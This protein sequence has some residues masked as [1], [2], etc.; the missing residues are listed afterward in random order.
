MALYD[1][2]SLSL[3]EAIKSDC[4]DHLHW[5]TQSYTHKKSLRGL[6]VGDLGGQGQSLQDLSKLGHN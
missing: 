1:I 6:D 3:F 4:A 2:L 5:K